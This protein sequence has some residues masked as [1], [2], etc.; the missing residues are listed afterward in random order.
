M[1]L[2]VTGC[3]QGIGRALCTLVLAKGHR[4]VAT[5]RN[6]NTGLSYLPECTPSSRLL[7]LSLDVTS[8]SSIDAALNATLAH[9]GRIDVIVNNAGMF[10]Y[11]NTENAD[12]ADGRALFETNYWGPLNITRRGVAIMRDVNP[13][14]S[15]CDGARGGVILNVTSVGGRVAVAGAA[16]YDAGKVGLEASTDCIA[17]ELKPEWNIHLSCIQPGV[18]RTGFIAGRG[19]MSIRHTQDMKGSFKLWTSSLMI[20]R[21]R[22]SGIHQRASRKVSMRRLFLVERF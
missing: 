14:S 9:F 5:A 20:R 15:S 12:E 10:I 4:L 18:V 13:K 16:F 1:D 22:K 6:P 17:Q 21:H 8:R 11:G 2:A 7:K 19:L 3:S